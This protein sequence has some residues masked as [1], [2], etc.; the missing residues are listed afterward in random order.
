[1]L[2]AQTNPAADLVGSQE[3]PRQSEDQATS[4]PEKFFAEGEFAAVL[5][6]LDYHDIDTHN[7]VLASDVM[8]LRHNQLFH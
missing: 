7:N 3:R 4:L 8:I 5:E 2:T 6:W 1:M